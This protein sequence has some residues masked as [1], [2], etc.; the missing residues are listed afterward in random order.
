M[1]FFS[2]LFRDPVEVRLEQGYAQM[3]YM[4]GMA[5]SRDAATSMAR[6]WVN[7]AKKIV[8]E[9]GA[10]KE[11]PNYGDWLL[12]KEPSDP[13]L[14][15]RLES[16]RAE[17]V[18]NEDIRWWH[19]QTPLEKVLLQRDDELARL[20]AFMSALSQGKSDTE[21][22]VLVWKIH[23]NFGVRQADA[24]DRALPI[25]LKKRIVEFLE[26]HYSLTVYIRFG[27]VS[28]MAASVCVF[29]SSRSGRLACDG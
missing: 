25:E 15:S 3:Y 22:G 1:G 9:T 14:H 6:D 11:P 29:S 19:N 8:R 2:K 16:G 4:M 24:D 12:Q 20:T 10:D 7:Q 27:V 13:A 23:P 26:R 18:R 21:A 28:S 17:G 5:P